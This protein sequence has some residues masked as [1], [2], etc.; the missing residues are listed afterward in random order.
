MKDTLFVLRP[1]FDDRGTTY[2]C[3]FSAQVIGFL[4]YYPQVRETVNVVELD[5]AKPRE[6]LAGLLGTAHQAAPMLVLGGPGVPVPGITI[7]EANGHA[8]VERTGEILRYLAA[9]RSV[10]FPH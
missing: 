4:T 1:D 8:F 3:P 6:P 10:A 5:F 2:F 9:T 7:S